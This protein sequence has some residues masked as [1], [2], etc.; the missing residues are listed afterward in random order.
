MK[1]VTRGLLTLSAIILAA[2][3]LLHTRAS[4]KT[5][6]AVSESNI[7]PFFGN[8][9]KALWLIDSVVL[10]TLAAVFLLMA[11]RP[12]LGSRPVIVVLAVIPG[13]TATFLYKFLGNFV[14][15]HLLIVASAA[16]LIAGLGWFQSVE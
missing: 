6:A 12:R 4:P 8:S 9:L 1:M 15:A 13:A 14:P 11:V 10:F 2:G 5:V 16:A 7:Q 3:C